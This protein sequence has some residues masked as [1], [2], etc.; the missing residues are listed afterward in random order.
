MNPLHIVSGI[1]GI[2]LLLDIVLVFVFRSALKRYILL[3][4]TGAQ[5]TGK[6]VACK[7]YNS[8]YGRNIAIKYEFETSVGDA[9]K[10][11]ADLPYSEEAER[12]YLVGSPLP[13][14]YLQDG[15]NAM[16]ETLDKRI[17]SLAG[18]NKVFPLIIVPMLFILGFLLYKGY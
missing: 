1:I 3:R 9:R 5:A 17:T 11:H 12:R 7:A 13:I 18:F 16:R 4:D 2:I 15:L 6:I 14:L 10:G 8:K